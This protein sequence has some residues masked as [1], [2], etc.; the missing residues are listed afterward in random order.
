MS[1][2]ARDFASA[3]TS[4][5]PSSA[6]KA[7]FDVVPLTKHIGAEICGIDL[8]EQPDAETAAGD[9]QAWLDHSC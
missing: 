9:H 1:L 8:R 2:S 3:K 7:P 5:K 6:G 4:A